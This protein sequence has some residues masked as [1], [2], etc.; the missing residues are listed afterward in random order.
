MITPYKGKFKV[1]QVYKG[2]THRGLD[3]VGL[4][5]KNIYS[6]VDGTVEVAGWDSHPTGG[7]GLYIRI[8][9][10]GDARR[11]YFAH[12]SAALVKVGQTVRLGDLI[13]VEGSTGHSTGSHLHYEVRSLPD[14]TKYLDVSSISGIPNKLGEVKPVEKELTVAEAKKIIKEKAGL[15]DATIQ[16]L[17]FYEYDTDLILKLA[18]AMM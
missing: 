12:L 4:D 7:M 18:K 5:D 3:L 1:T 16:Y 11:Y 9:S 14:N 17:D 13:G 15:S 2:A 6:T 8:N 10:A